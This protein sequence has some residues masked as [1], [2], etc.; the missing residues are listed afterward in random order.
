MSILR[1]WEK[2]K[3][4]IVL[5]CYLTVIYILTGLMCAWGSLF[6][7]HVNQDE[8]IMANISID[9]TYYPTHN[10]VDKCKNLSDLDGRTAW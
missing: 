10:L 5:F 1:V 8:T 2:T 6:G 9:Q 3:T 4:N 7:L